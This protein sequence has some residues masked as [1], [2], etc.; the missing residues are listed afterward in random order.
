VAEAASQLGFQSTLFMA[1]SDY[2]PAWLSS[3]KDTGANLVWCDPLPVQTLHA[4]MT[5]HYTDILNLPLGFDSPEFISD[6]A[7][8]LRHSIQSPPPEIWVSV[9]SGVIA[10]ATC[11][12]FPETKIH[13]VCVAKNHGNIGHAI[14]H[15]APEKFYRPA[16]T[17]PPY[18]ACPFSDA[19]LWQFAEKQAVSGAYVLNVGI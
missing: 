1:R 17:P 8:V 3:I 15:I 6:M 4:Q 19:K 11:A 2:V 9:V 12:A 16:T 7:D 5:N 13:A 10:R 14:P 18:P